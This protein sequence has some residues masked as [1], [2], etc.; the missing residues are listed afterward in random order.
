[1][2]R[3]GRTKNTYHENDFFTEYLLVPYAT[4]NKTR[5]KLEI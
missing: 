4:E 5:N 3:N 1:M 2:Q